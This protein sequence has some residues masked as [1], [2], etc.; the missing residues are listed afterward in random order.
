[1]MPLLIVLKLTRSTRAGTIKLSFG[2][3][4]FGCK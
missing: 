1:M 2:P 3:F 4:G